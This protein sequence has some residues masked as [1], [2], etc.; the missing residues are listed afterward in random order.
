MVLVPVTRAWLVRAVVGLIMLLCLGQAAFAQRVTVSLNQGWEFRQKSDS[1]ARTE[2]KWYPAEVLGVVYT[3]L[4]RNKII[5]DPFFR[6][7]EARL[8]RIENASWEYR[9]TFEATPEISK[10]NHIDLVFEGLV[11]RPGNTFT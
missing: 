8:Q 1:A 6:S 9:S 4:L 11:C 3:D 5:P 10:R 2:G 7:N